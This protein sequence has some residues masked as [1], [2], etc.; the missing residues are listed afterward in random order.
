[1][2]SIKWQDF[3]DVLTRK[4]ID[5]KTI[6]DFRFPIREE[7]KFQYCLKLNRNYLEEWLADKVKTKPKSANE[8]AKYR[9]EG[10]KAYCER[11]DE[12]AL[13]IYNLSVSAAPYESTEFALALANR[14]AVLMRLKYYE[15]AAR[16]INLALLN[17]NDAVPTQKLLI[18]KVIVLYKLKM[19]KASLDFIRILYPKEDEIDKLG[20]K[21]L[22]QI[23][24][25]LLSLN[26]T[27]EKK[28]TRKKPLPIPV[29][30]LNKDFPSA[31]ANVSLRISKEKGRHVIATDHL[32]VGDIIFVEKPF[33]LVVLPEQY[34]R[35]CHHCCKKSV[36]FLPCRQCRQAQFCSEGCRQTAWDSYHRWE[37]G[38]LDICHSIGIAHLGL[39]VALLSDNSDEYG[40]VDRLETHMKDMNTKDLYQY[41]L[42]AVLL[43]L[44]LYKH[45]SFFFDRSDISVN[46]M[47]TRIFRHI[48]QLICNG[49]AITKV[50][51]DNETKGRLTTTERQTRIATAIYPS[52]SMMNHSCDQNISHSFINEVLVVQ[53]S[54][55]IM[56]DDEVF[57]CYGPHYSSMKRKDRQKALWDQYFFDCCCNRCSNDDS[58]AYLDQFLAFRCTFCAGPVVEGHAKCS[59]CGQQQMLVEL[60]N[61][62]L[63]AH[64]GFCEGERLLESNETE[65][66]LKILEKSVTLASKCLYI[67]NSELRTYKDCLARAYA[68][69]GK[70]HEAV[71]I[72]EECLD[73]VEKQYGPYSIQLCF[74]LNKIRGLIDFATSKMA[75][76]GNADSNEYH[77]WMKKDR[78]YLVKFHAICKRNAEL[79]RIAN[80]TDSD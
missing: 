78:C 7:D 53:A 24:H 23:Y 19:Y 35:H 4:A 30:G 52:A 45:T 16:D 59:D 51:A 13:T 50:D 25:D 46:S 27:D 43:T 57:N 28:S 56:R 34:N 18:R 41:A 66:A 9:S 77:E 71:E 15:E 8:S 31:S 54:K 6:H 76:E 79:E 69:L 58:D 62:A 39:R 49:H 61:M 72:V 26:K 5:T 73:S 20:N 70:F 55:N 29:G 21:E 33:A 63:T 1:M 42:T 3:L 22:K 38:G 48:A 67:H 10:N 44:Y 2:A 74:E 11:N 14:S 64:E 12:E 68:D 65:K 47:G 40:R 37:C 60:L 75:K 32:T 17:K 36:A 80:E